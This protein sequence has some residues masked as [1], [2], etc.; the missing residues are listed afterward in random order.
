LNINTL[1][2]LVVWLRTSTLAL[3]RLHLFLFLFLLE[4]V[5]KNP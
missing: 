1:A 4:P 2:S 3:T 5:Q